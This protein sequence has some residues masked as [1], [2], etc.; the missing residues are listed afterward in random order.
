MLVAVTTG[1]RETETGMNLSLDCE[2]DFILV[3]K[4]CEYI[5]RAGRLKAVKSRSRKGLNVLYIKKATHSVEICRYDF[6]ASVTV[7]ALVGK[8]D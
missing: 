4:Q 7:A 1:K 3:R 5:L 6:Q 2:Y 8:R